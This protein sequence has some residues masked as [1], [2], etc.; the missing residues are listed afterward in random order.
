MPAASPGAIRRWL[1]RLSS[2]WMSLALLGVVFVHQAVGS[3][4]FVIRQAFEVNEM[5]WFNGVV[6]LVLWSLICVCLATASVVRIPWRWSR[7]GAHLTHLGVIA[8]VAT[9][10]IYF[11][12]KV[13]GEALLLRH[14][15]DVRSE[16]GDCR[17]LPNPG[18]LQTM[19]GAA[20]KVEAI[21]PHWTILSP[22]GKSQQAWAIMVTVQFPDGKP[23]SATLIEDRP[24]LTQYTLQGRQPTSWLPE[25][26]S[27]VARDG[28]LV[29]VEAGGAE[30]LAT[31][32][33]V[34]ARTVEKTAAG[35]RSLEI[36]NITPDFQLI[37][38]E[39]KGQTG[40]MVE[41]TLKTPTG[42]ESGSAV[43]DKPTLTRFQRARVKQVPDARL[44]SIALSPAPCAVAYHQ[45][46]PAL[47]VRK[48][49][50][51][52]ADP[53]AP[54]RP[55]DAGRVIHTA[56]PKLPR[57]HD[58]GGHVG[59]APL[60]IPAGTVDGVAFTVTGFAPYAD[61][62]SEWVEDPA[63][64]L[65]PILDLSF[66]SSASAQG[67]NKVL[68]VTDDASVIDDT[69]LCWLR[70]A[71]AAQLGALTARLA[72]QFPHV[73]HEQA[74]LDESKDEA[75]R[76][77]IVFISGPDGALTLWLGQ[78]GR[79]LASFP[80]APGKEV[81]ARM[82]N[83]TIRIRLNAQVEHPR[84]YTRPVPVPEDQRESRSS[85][86][87]F[88]SWIE[89]TATLAD[90]GP[91]GRRDA[92]AQ[93]WSTWVPYTPFPHLPTSIGD[94]EGT[95]TAYAPRPAQLAVPGAG[96][97]EL[98]YGRELLELPGELWMTGFDVP[99]RPGSDDP[100][101]YF[102]GLAFGDV[103]APAA[104]AQ[105]ATIHMNYPLAWRDLFFF[106]AGWDPP[107]QAL[108][109][110]GVGNRPAGAWLLA[111]SILLA[112]GMAWSGVCAAMRKDRPGAKP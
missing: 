5:E 74:V 55:L 65:H 91:D 68:A 98:E 108:T 2:P 111:A 51:E 29:A 33:R 81:S 42:Q 30:V 110:L 35:E 49:T 47:W 45:N 93:H 89:V 77:R 60:A 64:P 104:A 23:F 50:Q 53:Q 73:D 10:T 105:R 26:R 52:A 75:A 112:V 66:S 54:I 97:F 92:G 61:L 82:W 40:T 56:L 25:Y 16:A 28:R 67:L 46:L 100:S 63:V 90:R 71:D 11:A 3:A 20:A 72:A 109:V 17:L 62:V 95:L 13:E 39:F 12:C 107:F 70:A 76:T 96:S 79:N 31:E 44:K 7:A 86:G 106:Q 78:P 8:V 15:V 38:E 102:C 43:V 14:Y 6:S 27:V 19:G 85:V 24:D 21:L 18:Y 88:K 87:S 103:G 99:R 48:P 32:L 80:I 83:D 59:G 37:S 36:T 22:E 9:S 1:V 41:W 58:H 94:G 101:E 34:K 69:P 84:K 57:Y 4:G